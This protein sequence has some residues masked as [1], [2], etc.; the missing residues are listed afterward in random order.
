MSVGLRPYGHYI[1]TC[2]FAITIMSNFLVVVLTVDG[3][4]LH[5][6]NIIQLN[7]RRD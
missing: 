7:Y 5:S 3:F 1:R 4:I 6:L 2:T